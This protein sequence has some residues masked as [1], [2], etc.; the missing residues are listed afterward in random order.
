[1]NFLSVFIGGG[2]GA[3]ARWGLFRSWAKAFPQLPTFWA[4]LLVNVIG[5]LLIG[6][7]FA[8][9]MT[10]PASEN[11]KLFW[12]VGF[13]GGLT[14]FS[15]FGLDIFQMIQSKSL[16]ATSSYFLFHGL[17]CIVMVYLGHLLFQL[18]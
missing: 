1:M 13:L 4:T 2:L 11:F 12:L 14:T 7:L 16:L 5:C 3:L 18:R 9:A 6:Y 15:A 10:K 8:F 17:V